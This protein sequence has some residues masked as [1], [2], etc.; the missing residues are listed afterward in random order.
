MQLVRI[1]RRGGIIAGALALAAAQ[2]FL[3]VHTAHTAHANTVPRFVTVTLDAVHTYT[4]PEPDSIKLGDGGSYNIYAPE[5]P[6][7]R[8]DAD[9]DTV[10]FNGGFVQTWHCNSSH[11]QNWAFDSTS[12]PGLYRIRTGVNGK[13]LDEDN[14][15]G[16]ATGSRLQMWDCLGPGQLNQFFWLVR[17]DQW[18]PDMHPGVNVGIWILSNIGDTPRAVLA[19]DGWRNGGEI[20]VFDRGDFNVQE[21]WFLNTI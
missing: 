21:K 18:D 7:V 17:N 13:C 10:A 19:D 11:N 3:V 6:C 9:S 4:A 15:S 20:T 14:T 16:G 2:L 5:A 12:V 1:R 8:L